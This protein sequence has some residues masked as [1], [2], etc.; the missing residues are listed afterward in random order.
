MFTVFNRQLILPGSLAAWAALTALVILLSGCG[1]D[2]ASGPVAGPKPV[3]SVSIDAPSQD[4]LVGATLPLQARVKAFDGSSLDDR[5]VTWTSDDATIAT[6]SATGEVRAHAAGVVGIRATSEGRTGLLDVRVI[7]PANLPQLNALLP[8]RVDAG[9]AGPLVVRVVGS[10]FVERSRV[11]WNGIDR[12]T[13]FISDAEV[14]FTLLTADLATAVTV[15]VTVFTSAPGGGMSNAH[16]FVISTP[17]APAP[18]PRIDVLSPAQITA[19]WAMGFTLTIN[20]NGFTTQSRVLW[21]GEPRET[22]FVS[23]T[24]L[25][26]RVSMGDVITARDVMVAV[27]TPAPGGGRATAV[28]PVRNIPVDRVDLLSPFGGTWTWVNHSFPVTA[29]PRSVLGAELNDRQASWRIQGTTAAGVYPTGELTA[30]VYGLQRGMAFV[31]ATVE[32]V[33]AQRT[34]VV[35]DTPMFDIVYGAGVGP[36]QHLVLWSLAMGEGPRRLPIPLTAFDPS[37]APSG[38]DIVFTGVPSDQVFGGNYD[39]YVVARDGS[40]LRRLTTDDAVDYEAAWS[41]DG[42][43]IAFTSFRNGMRNVWV[44]N[45]DGSNPQRLTDANVGGGNPGSG[46]SAGDAAWS[47]DGSKLVYVVGGPQNTATLWIMNADGSG[48][49][50]LTTSAIGNAYDPAWS[51]DGLHIAFRREVGSPA[52]ITLAFVAPTNGSWSFPVLNTWVMSATPSFSPDGL[53]LLA[54]NTPQGS[55][56]TLYAVPLKSAGDPRI[57]M[58]TSLGG[59]RSARWIRRP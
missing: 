13:Q 30:R 40:N 54:S 35:H 8:A 47:P 9:T 31:E 39:L 21:D 14:R 12:P 25:R 42:S 49:R 52:Q 33:S 18:Q 34:V 27:E 58:P 29:V 51:A 28:F 2:T 48:K 55:A 7:A 4:V 22:E 24:A 11:H 57:V 50:Q 37:P 6:V 3:A 17:D 23:A 44:M 46:G 5:P 59:A 20:G 32:G 15:P 19:G 41:P 45:A 36:E 1:R 53:W 26:I 10:G 43:R 56:S 38:H 16:T